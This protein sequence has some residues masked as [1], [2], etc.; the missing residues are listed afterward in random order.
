MD[1]LPCMWEFACDVAGLL[2]LEEQHTSAQR[3]CAVS[4]CSAALACACW[5]AASQA[6]AA[7]SLAPEKRFS[8]A[9]FATPQAATASSIFCS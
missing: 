4:S 1:G 8:A 7:A 2:P 9:P 3:C 6:A 5:S